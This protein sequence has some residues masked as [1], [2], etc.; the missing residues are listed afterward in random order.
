MHR[1]FILFAAAVSLMVVNPAM[2]WGIPPQIPPEIEFKYDADFDCV[3]A[4]VSLWW[5]T[6]SST[7]FF[8]CL[9]SVAHQK[10]LCDKEGCDEECP[11]LRVDPY[12]AYR[13]DEEGGE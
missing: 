9:S 2:P 4:E 12:C 1:F 8:G 6:L 5:G 3:R 11:D 10:E 7:D 13:G